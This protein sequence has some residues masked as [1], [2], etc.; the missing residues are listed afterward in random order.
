MMTALTNFVRAAHAAD[1]AARGAKPRP[2]MSARSYSLPAPSY[3]EVHN[4][5][6]EESPSLDT[7]FEQ[8]PLQPSAARDRR[9]QS[10]SIDGDLSRRSSTSK[11]T[12]PP[13]APKLIPV[14][15][16][17]VTP[18]TLQDSTPGT[19]R[20]H[21]TH[22]SLPPSPWI[23]SKKGPRLQLHLSPAIKPIDAFPLSPRLVPTQLEVLEDDSSARMTPSAMFSRPPEKPR[24]RKSSRKSSA[25]AVVPPPGHGRSFLLWFFIGDLGLGTRTSVAMRT[26]DPAKTPPAAAEVGVILSIVGHVVGLFVFIAAH[27]ID[28]AVQAWETLCMAAWLLQWILL[29][30]TGRTV[31]S[32]CFVEAHSL[33]MREWALVVLEDHEM[34]GEPRQTSRLPWPFNRKRRGLTRWQV[35]RSL[36]ELYCIHDVT[37]EKFLEEGAGLQKLE[38]WRKAKEEE[39]DDSDSE[40]NDMIV[41]RQDDEILQFTKTPRIQPRRMSGGYF[42][43]TF[44]SKGL[45][46]D[47]PRDLVKNIKWASSMAISAYGLHVHIVDLPP[48]FTP[49]GE[50]FSKQTFAHL[51]RLNPDDVLHAEIQT[52]DSEAAYCPTFYVIK[53]QERKVVAVAI[54]G[55]QSFQDII[56]DLEMRTEAVDMPGEKGELR[57]HAGIWRAAQT[58]MQEDSKLLATVRTALEEEPDYGLVFTGHS[59]G[60]AIASAAALLIGEYVQKPWDRQGGGKWVIKDGCGLPPGR[61]M[62]AITFAPPATVTSA[63]CDRAT[64]GRVPLVLCVVLGAD[65]IPRTGHGQAR[66]LRRVLGALSRVRRRHAI[67]RE[68]EGDARVHVSSSWWD[69]RAIKRTAEPDAVMLDRKERI[70]RELWKLRCDVEDD[71]YARVKQ[72]AAGSKVDAVPPTPWLGPRRALHQ[73]AARRQAI[74]GAT[75]QSEAATGGILLP[76]GKSIWISGKELYEI[77]SPLAFFSLPDLHPKLFAEHFPSAYESALVEDIV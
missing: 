41:T 68:G 7:V 15:M 12:Q 76:A 67:A 55:T 4:L 45:W 30:L 38:G 25:D 16:S 52:L 70:E 36:W 6:P 21:P 62:R 33:I 42:P 22:L 69:W 31:L 40:D 56:V 8:V 18:F 35:L 27:A 17:P 71:L 49:S 73:L 11:R 58:L 14:H 37:R 29:N 53:D 20:L 3:E 75:L 47:K 5:P 10:A 72:R 66:E 65:I 60:G 43:E 44:V 28:L 54:R 61:L 39:Q 51:S 26:I 34:K 59:L 32:R 9:R 74:D 64:L 77:T 57:C 13:R 19:P 2:G 23:D 48:T 50:R 63:L 46:D 1:R 24:R